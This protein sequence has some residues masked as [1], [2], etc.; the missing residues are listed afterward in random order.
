MNIKRLADPIV[1]KVVKK[2]LNF[3]RSYRFIFYKTQ[4]NIMINRT[5]NLIKNHRF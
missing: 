1:T 4:Y 3:N 2:F 5:L